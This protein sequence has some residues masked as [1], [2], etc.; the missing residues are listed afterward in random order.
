MVVIMYDLAMQYT[1]F[2]IA[3]CNCNCCF[4]C[5]LLVAQHQNMALIYRKLCVNINKKAAVECF[6][7]FDSS[8]DKDESSF[9]RHSF[10]IFYWFYSNWSKHNIDYKTIMYAKVTHFVLSNFVFAVVHNI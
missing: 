4:F 10:Q 8:F 3:V 7:F 5:F 1:A 2:C 9:I 6:A